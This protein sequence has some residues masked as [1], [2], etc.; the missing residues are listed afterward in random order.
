M[1]CIVSGILIIT[2][3]FQNEA[4]TKQT[5]INKTAQTQQIVLDDKSKTRYKIAFV[6]PSFTIAAYN[7][8]FYVF[9]HKHNDDVFHGN[10]TTDLDL[11]T[12]KIP[13]YEHADQKALY[14]F[15]TFED[16]IQQVLPNAEISNLTDPDV[17]GGKI[18]GNNNTVPRN[19]AYDIL[20]FGHQEYV[21]QQE[22]NNIKQFVSN[23]GTIIMIDANFFY[24]EVRYD[25]INQAATFVKGH[26]FGFDGRQV[27]LSVGERWKNETRDWAGSNYFAEDPYSGNNQTYYFANNPFNY[28]RSEENYV[29]N[30]TDKIILD[31]GLS[32][33]SKLDSRHIA[34]YELDSGKGKVIVFGIGGEGEVGDPKFENFLGQVVL[35]YSLPQNSISK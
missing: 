4:I 26:G 35:N 7:H 10:V 31:Y 23:G 21:T 33:G 13:D 18:F 11:L 3:S 9:Y 28:S 32:L 19:N 20:I 34:T 22:Y 8:H 12:S 16:K 25:K 6:V 5:N 1:L 2:Y 24:A 14:N 30:P 15:L 17:D 29:S 27:F